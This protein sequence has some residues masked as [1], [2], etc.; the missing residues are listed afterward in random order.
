MIR[1]NRQW[2][3]TQLVK[4]EDWAMT[5][6]SEPRITKSVHVR[7]TDRNLASLNGTA[8]LH[9]LEKPALEAETRG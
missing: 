3:Q 1:T 7:R 9:P 4:L 8:D 2:R 5:R 6:D